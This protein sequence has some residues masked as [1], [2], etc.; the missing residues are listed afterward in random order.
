MSASDGGGD[1]LAIRNLIIKNQDEGFARLSQQISG[2]TVEVRAAT[3]QLA[4]HSVRIDAIA[5]DIQKVRDRTH[6]MAGMIQRR[7]S[8]RDVWLAVGL[9]SGTVAVI[10]FVA[11]LPTWLTP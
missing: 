10:K 8:A 11:L 4:V 5:A 7:I 2:L 3:T 9:I 6:A 1:E